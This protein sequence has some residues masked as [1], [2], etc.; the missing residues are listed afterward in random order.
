[1]VFNRRESRRKTNGKVRRKEKGFCE[2][3]LTQRFL[4]S[5]LALPP[6][7][8]A[9]HRLGAV[10][11][12]IVGNGYMIMA[13]TAFVVT[14]SATSIQVTLSSPLFTSQDYPKTDVGLIA[15]RAF[16]LANIGLLPVYA[17]WWFIEPVMHSLGQPDSL[18][19][20]LTPFL[21][22]LVLGQPGQ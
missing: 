21:R 22:V 8:R 14:L 12:G 20:G 13:V 15:Q 18:A 6:P 7:D 10:Q 11:L 16:L 3:E 2:L 4:R 19:K 17:L 1:M 5:S 9:L